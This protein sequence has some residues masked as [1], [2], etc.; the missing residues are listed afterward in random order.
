MLAVASDAYIAIDATGRIVAWNPAAQATFGHHHA[1]AC[2]RDG[3]SRRAAPASARCRDRGGRIR[4]CR[5]CGADPATARTPSRPA[6]EARAHAGR[7][8]AGGRSGCRQGRGY[9]DVGAYFG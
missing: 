6:A 3:T 9:D 4:W 1:H 5:V 8:S 2:G 7:G